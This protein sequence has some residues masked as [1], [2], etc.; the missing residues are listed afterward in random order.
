M[1]IISVQHYRLTNSKHKR[2]WGRGVEEEGEERR[3]ERE[4]GGEG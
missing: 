2:E 1:A 3:G 4:K